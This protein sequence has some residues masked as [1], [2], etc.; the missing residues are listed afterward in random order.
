MRTVTSTELRNHASRLL[1][2]VERGEIIRVMRHGRPI[3]CVVP[4]TADEEQRNWKRPGLRLVVPGAA[5]AKAVLEERL[6]AP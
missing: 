4:A 6:S 1:T 2:L 5:L 3:A